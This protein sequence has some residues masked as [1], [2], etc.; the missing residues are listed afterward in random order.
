MEQLAR[1]LG[2]S[3]FFIFTSLILGVGGMHGRGELQVNRRSYV[4]VMS[5]VRRSL[6]IDHAAIIGHQGT[7]ING[8]TESVDM[9]N[10]V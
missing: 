7:T 4:V 8:Q 5:S 3:E 10:G 6:N 1:R 9:C 2:Y